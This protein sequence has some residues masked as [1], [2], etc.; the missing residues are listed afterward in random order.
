[1]VCYW[2]IFLLDKSKWNNHSYLFGLFSII[3]FYADANNYCSLD[4]L[5][6]KGKKIKNKHVPNIQ[7]IIPRL[8]I[9]LLYFY[10]ALKKT[11]SDW[12]AGYSMGNLGKSKQFDPLRWMGLSND[13]INLYF[14]HIAGFMIDLLSPFLLLSDKTRKI[15]FVVMISF[16]GM[17]SQ[18]FNIGMF[19]YTCL[20]TMF[21]FNHNDCFRKFLGDRSECIKNEK[22]CVYDEDEKSKNDENKKEKSDSKKVKDSAPGLKHNIYLFIGL[23][24]MAIQLF[25]PYSHFLT[26]G[27]NGWTQ[28][29]YGYSWD[30]M[31]HSFATQHTKIYYKDPQTGQDGY[32]RTDSYT[33]G[34]ASSRWTSHPDQLYQYATCLNDRLRKV[35]DKQPEDPDLEIYFDCWK[36]MNKRFHQRTYNP[37]IDIVKSNWNPFQKPSYTLPLLYEN[38]DMRDIIKDK[39]KDAVMDDPFTEV[40]FI[41]DFPG[42]FLENFLNEDFKNTTIELL[43][44][45]IEISFPDDETREILKV[46]LNQKVTLP[47]NQFHNVHT[48]GSEPSCYM[49]VFENNTH[50]AYVN[51]WE[52]FKEKWENEIADNEKDS[53]VPANEQE[54]KFIQ[55][56]NDDKEAKEIRQSYNETSKFYKTTDGFFRGTEKRI[57]ILK[58]TWLLCKHAVK[59]HLLDIPGRYSDWEDLNGLNFYWPDWVFSPSQ[60]KHRGTRR[61]K[62]AKYMEMRKE[63]FLKDFEEELKGEIGGVEIDEKAEIKTEL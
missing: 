37:Q 60:R 17:N 43:K 9:F 36:S 40:T 25:L 31:I 10:A 4:G 3:F 21:I 48:V 12:L 19:P 24:Y 16:H 57:D 1:M 49:Y 62:H 22:W 34:R 5:I 27:Y 39:S 7:Y 32:L 2:Y 8:Q 23:F 42:M 46:E 44:G 18:L 51:E 45:Q 13:T 38:D 20:A 55:D 50:R 26:L 59:V 33:S 41:S 52:K 61:I 6:F 63:A 29:T 54:N 11:D 56:Y 14:V 58:R 35:L 28:G 15:G 47:P 53:Y 30:M